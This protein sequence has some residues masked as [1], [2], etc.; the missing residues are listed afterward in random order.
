MAFHVTL[1]P[2][3]PWIVGVLALAYMC[4]PGL[5][6]LY[7]AR[8]YHKGAQIEALGL[9]MAGGPRAL[10]WPV[11]TY[12]IGVAI[13]LGSL[14]ISVLGADVSLQAPSTGVRGM[15]RAAG[16]DTTPLDIV[17]FLDPLLVFQFLLLAP[18]INIPLMLSEEL[19]WRGWLWT[20]LRPRGFWVTS[21]V[22]GLMWGLWHVPII[23]MGHNYP[24][25]PVWGPVIFTVFCLVYAPIFSFVRE[26][27]GSVWGA[28]ILHATTNGAAALSIVALTDPPVLWK[29]IIGLGG[30]IM[31]ALGS[32]LI[33]Y[34]YRPIAPD[35]ARVQETVT[36]AA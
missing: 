4:G 11:L 35:V 27:T 2:T 23:A 28:C 30:F 34:F 7:M 14:F 3:L 19:G 25:M 26:K 22:T 5:A 21:A 16:Q 6:G 24:G 32:A 31:L 12:L 36:P 15:M 10:V 33:G 8:R 18:L 1:F 9:R 29:G 17:P 20:A 13:I